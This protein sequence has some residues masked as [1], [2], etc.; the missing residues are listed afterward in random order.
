MN[1]TQPAVLCFDNHIP[2]DKT[3]RNYYLEIEGDLQAYKEVRTE[4]GPNLR[5]WMQLLCSAEDSQMEWFACWS[6]FATFL[7]P[8]IR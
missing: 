5:N 1:L 2:E 6:Y 8:G 7:S 3:R 4:S